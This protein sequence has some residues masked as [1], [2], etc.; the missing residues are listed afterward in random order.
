MVIGAVLYRM[1]QSIFSKMFKLKMLTYQLVMM[2][3][4]YLKILE[5]K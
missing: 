1:M 4:S 3:V 2:P 5:Y